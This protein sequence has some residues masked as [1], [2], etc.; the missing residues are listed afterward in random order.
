MRR[1]KEEGREGEIVLG[2]TKITLPVSE[3]I[4]KFIN[5]KSPFELSDLL[6]VVGTARVRERGGPCHKVTL[7]SRQ[8][9]HR[10]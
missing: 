3:L 6:V 7:K 1:G 9:P 5:T 2:C 10:M 4:L 8:R